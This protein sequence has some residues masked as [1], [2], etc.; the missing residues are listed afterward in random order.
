MS[1]N[2]NN[3]HSGNQN[4]VERARAD[5]I[6]MNSILVMRR[7]VKEAEVVLTIKRRKLEYLGHIMRREKCQL[8]QLIMQGRTQGKRRAGET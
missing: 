8:L 6:N 7:M 3:D 1:V 5:L 4:R 2:N